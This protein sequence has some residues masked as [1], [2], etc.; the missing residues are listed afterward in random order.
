MRPMF[1]NVT[2]GFIMSV[3]MGLK[4]THIQQQCLPFDLICT[5]SPDSLEVLT[6][7]GDR[8]ELFTILC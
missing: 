5:N 3:S 8:F 7:D 2:Q 4:H 1:I 6:V